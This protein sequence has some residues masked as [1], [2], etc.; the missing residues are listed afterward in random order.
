[1]PTNETKEPEKLHI[2]WIKLN[3]SRDVNSEY[4]QY[5]RPYHYDIPRSEQGTP[6]VAMLSS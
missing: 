4:E 3:I 6:R 1:M 5:S 2:T